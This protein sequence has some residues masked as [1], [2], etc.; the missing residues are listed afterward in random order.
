MFEFIRIGRKDIWLF[1]IALLFITFPWSERLNSVFIIAIILFFLFDKNLLDK[2]KSVKY[3]FI[4]IFPFLF[5][6]LLHILFLNFSAIDDDSIQTIEVKLSFI[7]LPF[8]ISC[9]NYLS[10]K[11]L[12]KIF[13]L[14]AFSLLLSVLYCIYQYYIT[15]Y[16]IE[17]WSK[18]FKRMYFSRIMHPGYYSNFFML[19]FIYFSIL[20]FN[21]NNLKSFEKKLFSFFNIFFFLIILILSSKVTFI[22]LF[23]FLSFLIWKKI[24]FYYKGNKKYFFLFVSFVGLVLF[25]IIT[26]GIR[27]RILE[28]KK[29]ITEIGTDVDFDNSTGSRL[30]AYKVEWG[31]IKKNFWKGY[32]TGQSNNVLLN[33]LKIKNYE[34]LAENKMHT[35]QQFF[36]TWLDLGFVGISSL[37][38]LFFYLFYFFIKNKNELVFWSTLC[39]FIYCLTDD[40]LEIQVIIV[41]FTL[42]ITLLLFQHSANQKK[43]IS[44]T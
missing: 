8:I 13:T 17:Q 23:F 21:D 39:L 3:N 25:F 15:Y 27:N 30:A 10:S 40:A 12:Q 14:F 20:L 26:P 6:F 19:A 42:L 22:V 7:L 9:E 2:C 44:K 36:H 37:L 16:A 24:S 33:E 4:K 35:H 11:A 43:I 29:E 5:F 31:L 28:T 34:D 41:F 1:L 38:F 18:I 32:G